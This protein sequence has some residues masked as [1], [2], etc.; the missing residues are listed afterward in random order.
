MRV[1]FC[2]H[3]R[4]RVESEASLTHS[5]QKVTIVLILAL[6]CSINTRRNSVNLHKSYHC[7]GDYTVRG[8]FGRYF[9][10]FA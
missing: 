3:E 1:L 4:V 5:A 2:E 9:L 6:I 8:R 10:N 7:T